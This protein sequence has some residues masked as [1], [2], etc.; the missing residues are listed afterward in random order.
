MKETDNEENTTAYNTDIHKDI[1][2][3][4]E[5]TDGP[6]IDVSTMMATNTNITKII[7]TQP[8]KSFYLTDINE[9]QQ[10][11]KTANQRRT[12]DQ[13]PEEHT[14]ETY[15]LPP[16]TDTEDSTDSGDEEW[17]TNTSPTSQIT[18]NH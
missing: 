2:G 3:M 18:S 12:E 14:Y 9:E 10:I 4:V 17:S 7:T 11:Q 16:L 13:Q 1:W 8:H 5:V 15:N 6:Q